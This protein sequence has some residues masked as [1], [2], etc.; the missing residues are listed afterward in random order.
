MQLTTFYWHMAA[1][2]GGKQ[3]CP[4]SFQTTWEGS[5]YMARDLRPSRPMLSWGGS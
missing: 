1:G 3:G 5:G 2:Q 4:H